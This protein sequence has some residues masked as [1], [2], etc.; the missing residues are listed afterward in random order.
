MTKFSRVQQCI[1]ISF[2]FCFACTLYC[3]WKTYGFGWL[4]PRLECS[5]KYVHHGDISL[6]ASINSSFVIR[7]AG[8]RVLK[9]FRIAPECGC[10]A[11]V[12][13]PITIEPGQ[14]DTIEVQLESKGLRGHV[15]KNVLVKS[16]DPFSPSVLLRIEATIV[17][18]EG[19]IPCGTRGARQSRDRVS[20]VHENKGLAASG[21]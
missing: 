17:N 2:L 12:R 1:L 9:I 19:D 6:G 21:L 10:T 8:S 20:A 7:N 18:P 14:N 13:A 11:V 15:S 4:A 3:G 16:N 5:R